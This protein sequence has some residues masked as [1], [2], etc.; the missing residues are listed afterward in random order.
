MIITWMS[1]IRIPLHFIEE[2]IKKISRHGISDNISA[3]YHLYWTSVFTG[4]NRAKLGVLEISSNLYSKDMHGYHIWPNLAV[5]NKTVLVE[6]M[7][8]GEGQW[9]TQWFIGFTHKNTFN[10][11]VYSRRKLGSCNSASG[12]DW[13]FIFYGPLIST[14]S[15]D[16]LGN[17]RIPSYYILLIQVSE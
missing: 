2:K 1:C 6:N 9:S 16:K 5:Q 10:C 7:I 14:L 4:R 17:Y 8:L 12:I 11:I 15:A 3:L 13:S